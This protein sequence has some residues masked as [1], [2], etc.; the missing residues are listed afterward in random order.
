MN[1]V[2]VLCSVCV[3]SMIYV[4][5]RGD[6]S[7]LISFYER[8]NRYALRWNRPVYHQR[9]ESIFQMITGLEASCEQYTKLW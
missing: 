5:L 4:R 3:A 6:S 7:N 1:Q 8:T 9:N 2:H